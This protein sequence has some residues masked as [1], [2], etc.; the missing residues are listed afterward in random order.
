M[1]EPAKPTALARRRALRLRCTPE[2]IVCVVARVRGERCMGTLARRTPLNWDGVLDSTLGKS[3]ITRPFLSEIY[4]L[5]CKYTGSLCDHLTA[6][7]RREPSQV[8]GSF[9]VRVCGL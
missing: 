4:D 2:C 3:F 5:F 8:E 6:R 7:P 1:Q 9:F